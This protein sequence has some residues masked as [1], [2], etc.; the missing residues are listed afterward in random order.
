MGGPTQRERHSTGSSGA[1]GLDEA[2]RETGEPEGGRG[3][4]ESDEKQMEGVHP[5]N[6]FHL[7]IFL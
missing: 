2:E 6:F 5:L 1:G 4:D 7:T 3:D